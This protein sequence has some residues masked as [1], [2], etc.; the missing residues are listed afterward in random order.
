M[1]RYDAIR[2]RYWKAVVHYGSIIAGQI[3]FC[4]RNHN[5]MWDC[6]Y[7]ERIY[8]RKLSARYAPL[9]VVR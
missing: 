9:A 3:V 1:F 5:G 2:I 6:I 8:D 4:A 7:D